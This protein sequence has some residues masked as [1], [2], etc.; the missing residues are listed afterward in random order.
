MSRY[1]LQYLRKDSE[2]L[3]NAWYVAAQSTQIDDQLLALKILDENLVFYRDS[4]NKVV[5]LEDACPH[6][7]M[8]LSMGQRVGDAIQ[9]GYHGLTF[10]ARGKC[11]NAP[12]QD[13]I[14]GNAIVRSYP[15]VEKYHLVWIWMGIPDLANE[16]TLLQLDDYDNET[17]GLTDGGM[18]ECQCHYLYLLDNLLDPSHVAWVHKTSFASEGTEDVALKIEDTETGVLVSRWINNIDPPPYY[19]E[20]LQFSG[21]VDRL[22][23]Y[24][25]IVPSI[26]VNMSTYARAGFGGDSDNLPE[27]SYRMRSYH[28]I[29][30]IDAHSTRYHWFQHYNTNI[31]DEGVRQKLNEGARGAFEEDRVVLEAVDRGMNHKK[32]AN[33]DLQLDIGSKKFRKKLGTMI[34]AEKE[35]AE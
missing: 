21:K 34:K 31:K 19:A 14:P 12:T 8:P 35:M 22:Q 4:N 13:K 32:R 10:D 7:K 24:E 16:S 15:V 27:D 26:A 25:A 23:Y 3:E 30:P 28:F 33:L 29:T 6:R 18:L 17:W 20:M 9:C 2:Y 5:A 11:I 1:E